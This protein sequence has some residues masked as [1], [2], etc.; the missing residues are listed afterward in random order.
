MANQASSSSAWLGK[1]PVGRAEAGAAVG[2]GGGVEGGVAAPTGPGRRPCA[3]CW[4]I[5]D[6]K[7]VFEP[8][9]RLSF[10]HLLNDE[11]YRGFVTDVTFEAQRKAAASS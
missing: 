2:E 1:S 9:D 10:L 8:A 3:R 4:S 6:G 5:R 11:L 7:L